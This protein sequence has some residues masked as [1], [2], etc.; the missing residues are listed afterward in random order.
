M[1]TVCTTAKYNFACI[2][3]MLLFFFHIGLLSTE[4]QH[5]LAANE[6]FCLG[7][8]WIKIGMCSRIWP[9]CIKILLGRWPVHALRLS[10]ERKKREGEKTSSR[11]FV[12]CVCHHCVKELLRKQASLIKKIKIRM[13]TRGWTIPADFWHHCADYVNREPK[14]WWHHCFRI[15]SIFAGWKHL[16]LCCVFTLVPD[17]KSRFLPEIIK[18]L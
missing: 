9:F 16:D 11:R 7:L 1:N 5:F 4:D 6:L 3:G 2:G 13:S 18:R 8:T 15:N 17:W 14:T 12:C 10:E